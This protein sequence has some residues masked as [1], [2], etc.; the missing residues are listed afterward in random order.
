MHFDPPVH[1]PEPASLIAGGCAALGDAHRR[2]WLMHIEG[3]QVLADLAM[4]RPGEE[5][6]RRH[7]LALIK[8]SA[9]SMADLLSQT[10]PAA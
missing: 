7:Y 10:A 6:M 2:E 4:G 5:G 9:A 1:P 8:A 3:Q